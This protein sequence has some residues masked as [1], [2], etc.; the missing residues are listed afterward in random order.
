MGN[1]LNTSAVHDA[2]QKEFQSPY[3]M[4]KS[5]I[6]EQ[7]KLPRKCKSYDQY[8]ERIENVDFIFYPEADRKADGIILEL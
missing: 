3:F 8:I 5:L 4:D 7:L 1:Y 6:L 2:Y